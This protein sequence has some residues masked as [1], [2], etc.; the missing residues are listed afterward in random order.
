MQLFVEF[1]ESLKVPTIQALLEMM[2]K[3]QQILLDGVSLISYRPTVLMAP[4]TQVPSKLLVQVPRYG[5]QFQTY[6]RIIPGVKLDPSP[7]IDCPCKSQWLYIGHDID[8]HDFQILVLSA[9]KRHGIPAMTANQNLPPTDPLMVEC[10]FVTT[11]MTRSTGTGHV[12]ATSQRS[13]GSWR[14]WGS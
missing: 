14:R 5:K 7:L 12:P 4:F 10:T 3:E 13:A 11:A 1:D 9:K 6:K 8:D 2:F